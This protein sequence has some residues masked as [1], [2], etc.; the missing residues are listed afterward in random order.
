M[1][2]RHSKIKGKICMITAALVLGLTGCGENQIPDLT[3]AEIQ[4]IGEY[5]AITMMKYDLNNKS[6]LMELSVLDIEE[7]VLEEN[8]ETEDSVGMGPVDDTP[9]VNAPGAEAET[10][11]PVRQEEY[12]MEEV[13][14]L[15][16]GMTVAFQ[17][18]EVYDSY[19]EE[20]DFFSMSASEG[21]KLLVLRFS[22]SNGTAQDQ[23]MDM[24]ASDAAFH[25]TVNGEYTR[26]A[27]TTMLLDDMT[28]FVGTIPAQGSVETVLVVEMGQE[29]ASH[30]SSLS[31]TVKNESKTYAMELLP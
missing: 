20:G 10:E 16:E 8:G 31:L 27:L 1:K 11:N 22:V 13:M 5:I 18:Q 15:P 6:R 3:N 23:E 17:G 4:A 26:R 14:G 2:M 24:L 19:P 12:S 28:T 30:I 29:T 21:K 25:V 9:V 7:S